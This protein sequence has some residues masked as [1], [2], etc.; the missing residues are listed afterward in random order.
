MT[1]DVPGAF[2][3]V[4]IGAGAAG[5]AAAAT[6]ASFGLSVL[7]VEASA[8]VGGTSA[9]SAGSL[10]VPNSCLA[11]T[12]G[13]DPGR[14][15]AYLDATVGDRSPRHLRRAFLERGPA[16]IDH[17]TRL[18]AID[19]A[20]YPYHPDYLADAEGATT[21]GRA[22]G[23][24]AFDGRL[25]GSDLDL[26]RPPL[27][28]FTI[29]GGM[30][31]D[32]TDINHLL[33]AH[34]RPASL[35]HAL[36]LVARHARDRLSR[37]RGTRL[38]MGN[39]LA[40]RLLWSL[41]RQGV[42]IRTRTGVEAI[43]ME[44]GRAAGVRIGGRTVAA[45]HGVVVAGGGFSHHARL[46]EVRY[47]APVAAY[48]AVPDSNRGGGIDL[49]LAAGGRLSD[50][51]ANAAFWAPSSVRRR[52]DGSLAVFPHFV[53]DRAKPGVIA[54]DRTGRRFVNES[55]S[56]QLF[57]EGMYRAGAIPCHLV[58]NG[59]FIRR[60]GLGM[61]RP[62]TRDLR[63]HLED[64]YIV[65]GATVAELADRIG[66][67]PA[68]LADSFARNDRYAAEGRDPEFGRGA[69]AYNRNLGDAGHGP[70]PCLGPM[71]RGPYYALAIHPAD[72]GTSIGIVTD[73]A[74]RV[75]GT[76]DEPIAGLY[77]AGNDMS[78][79]MGGVYPGPGI[80]IGPAMT[81]GHVAAC[82]AAGRLEPLR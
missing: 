40:G 15:E 67:D 21:G 18:G 51:H 31:V 73:E 23:A 68:I 70:N 65:S 81:F 75:L 64:G 25:L 37:P 36:G 13:D 62:R 55:T 22:L 42:D 3:L 7:L 10:W 80:T 48:S 78:S 74:A 47:P 11:A 59:D 77:A 5:M 50:G 17:L 54:V 46:R 35:A 61:I 1:D 19:L 29:L 57:V 32:R 24:R 6:G 8:H 76:D 58:C 82:H 9:L 39:A 72:I 71:G 66:A 14:A 28:E 38:V 2:D 4:V 44:A 63:R 20:P 26:L 45:R 60:Y 79:V 41:L 33:A 56:Y 49:L 16:M 43:V 69:N 34:R 53:L 52:A 30:M 27:P 12:A